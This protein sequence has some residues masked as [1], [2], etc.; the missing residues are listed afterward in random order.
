MGIHELSTEFFVVRTSP[1]FEARLMRGLRGQFD[2]LGVTSNLPSRREQLSVP[3][4][5]PDVLVFWGVGQFPAEPNFF[6]FE[7][8]NPLNFAIVLFVV[9]SAVV[10]GRGAD[11]HVLRNSWKEGRRLACE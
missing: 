9:L 4:F 2:G 3:G 6:V 8:P 7:F 10:F 11:P 1:M 5:C